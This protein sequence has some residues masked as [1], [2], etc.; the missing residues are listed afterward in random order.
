MEP[1]AATPAKRLEAIRTLSAAGAPVGVGFSPVIPG[2]NDHEMEA[3]LEA[4]ADAGASEAMI[5]VLRLPRE[6]KDLFKEWLA[7][8]H[9]D[10]A[11]R[12]MSLVRQMRGGRE[13]DSAFGGRMVGSGPVAEL[14]A[15][16]FTLACQRFGLNRTHARL[17]SDLFRRPRASTP[18]LDLFG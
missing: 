16:R 15:R 10:R 3:V 8:D 17:R 6:I 4:A 14:M 11:A 9:P 12:V 7:T 2:L 5:V 18:Q 13:N 1:R